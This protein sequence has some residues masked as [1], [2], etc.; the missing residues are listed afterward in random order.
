MGGIILL[1]KTLASAIVLLFIVTSITPM[2]VGFDTEPSNDDLLRQIEFA[3][4]DRFSS[5]VDVYIERYFEQMKKNKYAKV[6]GVAV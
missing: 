4:A 1:K 6:I 5:N 3:C 2:V